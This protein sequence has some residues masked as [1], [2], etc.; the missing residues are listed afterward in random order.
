MSINPEACRSDQHQPLGPMSVQRRD[1]CRQHPAHRMA[2]DMRT[3]DAK[4]VHQLM[5]EKG[6]V[7]N[8]LDQISARGF[9]ETWQMWRDNVEILAEFFEKWLET[10][11]PT[12]AMDIQQWLTATIFIGLNR[13]TIASDGVNGLH[14]AAPRP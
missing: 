6:G 10:E 9:A 5:I 2:D 8:V 11:Q 13:K 1:L 7:E 4:V 3:A 12:S 14:F